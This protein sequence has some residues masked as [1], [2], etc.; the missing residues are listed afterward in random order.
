MTTSPLVSI[1]IPCY[2]YGRYLPEAIDSALAQT[3]QPVEIIVVDD[4]STDNTAAA[5]KGYGEKIRYIYRQN[6]HLSAARN[7][8]AEAAKGDYVMFLDADDLLD[9][10][11]VELCLKELEA[12]PESAYIYT[13]MQ[14]FG[15]KDEVT[16]YPDFD[17]NKLLRGNFIHASA[18]LRAELVKRFRYDTSMKDGWEDY[19]FYL[20]LAENG[21]FGRLLD[22]PL[23]KY[24]KHDSMIDTVDFSKERQVMAQTIR[25]HPKLYSPWIRL[26]IGLVYFV[27]QHRLMAKP[28]RWLKRQLKGL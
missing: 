10:Q 18:L 9:P 13:Q 17:L 23:L 12:H 24:R 15:R 4:G 14:L 16:H 20:T 11:Y 21:H 6:G 1:I 3:Y 28:A 19:S 26:Q 8:G 22:K 7:T 5:A 25:R 27:R 2:N